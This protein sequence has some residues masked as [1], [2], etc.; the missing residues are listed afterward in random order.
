LTVAAG[1]G[2]LGKDMGTDGHRTQVI[3]SAGG[4]KESEGVEPIP[5]TREVLEQLLDD[6]DSKIAAVLAQTERKVREIV[7]ECVGLSLAMLRYGLT[8]TLV[9][10]SEAMA[11]LDAVQYLDGGPCVDAAHRPDTVEVTDDAALD[12]STWQMYAQASA[13]VGVRSSL[14]LPV[15]GSGGVV[16]GTVNLYASTADAFEGHVERLAEA[17][18]SSATRAVANADLSFSTR[19][20]AAQAP[21]QLADQ[22]E[23]DIA[24]GIIAG[25]HSVSIATA[26]ER[27]HTAASRAGITLLQ[28]A[29]AARGLLM[30]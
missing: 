10:S 16:I 29:R 6:G 8:F 12:E 11:G 5:E 20:A 1:T 21:A 25:A 4:P 24:L 23:V 9:A 27:L 18:S 22:K 13:A 30:P 19:L 3:R 7:P 15:L 2:F 26:T 14:T 17:L 28:A